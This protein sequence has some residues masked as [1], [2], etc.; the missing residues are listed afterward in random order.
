MHLITDEEKV[1]ERE[2]VRCQLMVFAWLAEHLGA[3]ATLE[4]AARVTVDVADELLGW[5]RCSLDLYEAA[6]DQV[7]PILRL[8]TI[9]GRKVAL[10]PQ[11]AQ[12]PAPPLRSVLE[13]G[14]QLIRRR[15]DESPEAGTI[16]F[17]LT[18]HLSASSIYVPIRQSGTVTGVISLHR[19]AAEAYDATALETLQALADHCASA[20]ARIQAQEALRAGEQRH[21]LLVENLGEG[22]GILDADE[23]FLFANP[24]AERMFGVGLGQLMGRPLKEYLSPAQRKIILDQAQQRAARPRDTFELAVTRPDGCEQTLLVTLTSRPVAGDGGRETFGVFRDI[25]EQISLQSQLRQ[26]QKLEALGQLAG[27]VAHDF[28]NLLTVVLG[29]CGL[30]KSDGLLTDE[31]HSSVEEIRL[32]AESAAHLTRQLLAFS[33]RETPQ[34]QPVNLNEIITNVSKMLRRLIGEAIPLHCRLAPGLPTIGAD[35]GM[36]EQVLLNLAVNARDAMPKGGRI[37]IATQELTL[38]D[39]DM[40]HHPQGRRG[41]FVVL[42]VQDTGCGIPAHL[43]PLIFEPF[44][45]TKEAARGTGLGLATVQTIVSQHQGWIEVDS[46]VDQGSTFSIYLPTAGEALTPVLA[47]A[48]PPG[49]LRGSEC[50]LIVEDD[51][52]VLQMTRQALR[53][54]G[55]TVQTA[56]SGVEALVVWQENGPQID[57]LITDLVLPQS[58]NGDELARLLRCRNPHLRVLFM[59]GYG[60]EAICPDWTGEMNDFL[61]VKPYESNTLL[62]AVRQTLDRPSLKLNSNEVPHPILATI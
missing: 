49:S 62:Q 59:S 8:E 57:L 44:F 56:S 7:Q 17:E 6:H 61:L 36:I 26:S 21:R 35:I 52:S 43:L 16:P 2:D 18:H 14:Q 15:S 24:A 12:W 28:N 38:R 58:L 42:R 1:G 34:P 53:A 32:A 54:Q 23:T 5:D 11:G 60:P 9:E 29:H 37:S 47:S 41:E 46:Q 51:V 25:T 45:T 22:L 48:L 55:Y 27:G 19:D 30:L 4:E 33:R 20:L 3:T 50:I 31:A 10:L 13:Q 40:A 39:D